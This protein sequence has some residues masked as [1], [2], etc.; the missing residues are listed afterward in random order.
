ML[1]CLL[2]LLACGTVKA[3]FKRGMRLRAVRG[4]GKGCGGVVTVR[5]PVTTTDE[6]QRSADAT[7]LPRALT[8]AS[9]PLPA[10]LVVLG[11][12]GWLCWRVLVS[13]HHVLDT[14]VVWTF[15][16]LFVIVAVQLVLV[17]F[18]G[19]MIGGGEVYRVAVL[20]PLYNEDP[21]VVIQMLSALLNQS[22]PP[23][24]IHVVDDGSTQGAYLEE[25]DWFIR[26]AAV[27]RI[28]ATWQRTPNEGKRH[29]QI[30]GFRKIRDGPP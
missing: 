16:V 20:V 24:E 8:G 23:A 13:R 10:I 28:Y 11:V 22:S 2:I 27:A 12:V 25:R 3:L 6:A 29:A 30:H 21:D 5:A 14:W 17:G 1:V 4:R 26:Q 7:G 19:R 18:E 9:G 15:D